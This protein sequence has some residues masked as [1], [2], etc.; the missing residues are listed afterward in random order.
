MNIELHPTRAAACLRASLYL[1]LAALP[2]LLPLPLWA[3][4]AACAV[5]AIAAWPRFTTRGK[6]RA[7]RIEP[8]GGLSAVVGAP[9]EQRVLRVRSVRVPRFFR[10]YVELALELSDGRSATL[11]IL[12]GLCDADAFRQLRKYLLQKG[13]P[14]V[15][16]KANLLSRLR[17]YR[18]TRHVKTAACNSRRA[19]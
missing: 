18:Y 5:V 2:W 1:S 10:C 8:Q 12:P 6:V 15:V 16:A 19:A 9:G 7:L 3:Q 11:F 13:A 14:A 4:C 17:A